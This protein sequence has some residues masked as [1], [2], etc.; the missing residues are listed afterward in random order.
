M[1]VLLDPGIDARAEVPSLSVAQMQIVEIAKALSSE[2]KILLLDEPT[3]S[4]TE[5]ETA[6]LFI[7][8]RTNFADNAKFCGYNENFGILRRVAARL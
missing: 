2:A 8:R 3:A 1:P 7:L 5:H 6:A 4:I